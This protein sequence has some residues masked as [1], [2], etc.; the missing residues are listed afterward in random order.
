MIFVDISMV[1]MFIF[2]AVFAGGMSKL[3]KEVDMV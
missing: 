1:I 3:F 2:S